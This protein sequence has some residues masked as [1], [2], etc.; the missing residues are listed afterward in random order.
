CVREKSGA[1]HF[2]RPD[3]VEFVRP[4]NDG[5]VIGLQGKCFSVADDARKILEQLPIM[6]L[7][8]EGYEESGIPEDEQYYVNPEVCKI[9]GS[10]PATLH[11]PGWNILVRGEASELVWLRRTALRTR[12]GKCAA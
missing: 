12:R 5:C 8:N 9:S 3:E 7:V 1:L 10:F 4:E 2:L 6:L 11:L